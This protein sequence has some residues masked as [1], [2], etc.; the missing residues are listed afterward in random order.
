MVYDNIIDKPHFCASPNQN[1]D[2][3]DPLS[4][5]L[6][7]KLQNMDVW[8]VGNESFFIHIIVSKTFPV[9]S[10]RKSDFMQMIMGTPIVRNVFR[11]NKTMIFLK[12][13]MKTLI[14]FC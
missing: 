3:Y 10:S 8:D 14:H 5:S 7:W 2:F 11:D 6:F 9:I 4:L 13:Q 12:I 1:K